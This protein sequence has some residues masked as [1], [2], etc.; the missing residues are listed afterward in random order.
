MDYRFNAQ[1]HIAI[2]LRITLRFFV[3]MDIMELPDS[4]RGPFPRL[5]SPAH[6]N[7]TPML[8]NDL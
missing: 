3:N 4:T 6:Y 8:C 7:Q 5:D 2:C 1:I